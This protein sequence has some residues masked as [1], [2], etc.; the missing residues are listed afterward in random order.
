MSLIIPLAS[1]DPDL[2]DR[3]AAI[4]AAGDVP[5]V[6]D[7]RWS[8]EQWKHVRAMIAD[9]KLPA[10]T[11][12]ATL[13]SGSSGFPRI[14][15]RSAESWAQSFAAVSEYLDVHR[16]D[17]IALPAPASS[18]LTL[19]SLAHSLDYGLT[20]VTHDAA[21]L[22]GTPQTLQRWMSSSLWAPRRTALIGGSH[23]D[24]Q[25]RSLAESQGIRVTAYYG[26]AELSFVALD[27]GSGLQA[28]PGVDLDIRDGILWVRSPFL[29]SGYLGAPGPL[30]TQGAW[31]SVGDHA[32]IVDGFL[33][34]L[35][36]EDDAILS[37]SATIVPEEVE[38]AL[39]SIPE[40][41][42]ACVF[43][44]PRESIGA[45]VAAFIEPE[46]GVTLTAQSLRSAASV[47]LAPAHCPRRW[48]AG[49]LPRTA[50]G[51]VARA[52]VA[53]RVL[54]GEVAILD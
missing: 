39:R 22:H 52:E 13:T 44:V 25:L 37:A 29:A 7:H 47:L 19:F 32:E 40:V 49:V 1:N 11:A 5:L 51:K 31:A 8:A 15:V 53:R 18:S 21:S 14:V 10:D 35:G 36:R 54:D 46:P 20:P 17:R 33:R 2:L 28:F 45:L 16:G 50:T 42:D 34:L 41:N 30:R 6:G 3:L 27:D 38:S 26:A 9:A 48:Y 24:S 12:W 23:L 4:R 43:G